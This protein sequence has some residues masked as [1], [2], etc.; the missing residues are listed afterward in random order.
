MQCVEVT[1]S[2]LEKKDKKIKIVI[3]LKQYKP[4]LM[5]TSNNR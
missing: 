1:R 4:N 3:Y 5:S 2:S